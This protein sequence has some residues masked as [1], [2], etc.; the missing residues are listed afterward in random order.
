MTL[1]LQLDLAC[2]SP[3]F[4]IEPSNIDEVCDSADIAATRWVEVWDET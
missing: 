4:W 2:G 1:W 3:L